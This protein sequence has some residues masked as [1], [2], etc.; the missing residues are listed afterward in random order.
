MP[1]PK[2]QGFNANRQRTLQS[3]RH[4]NDEKHYESRRIVLVQGRLITFN[5]PG[6]T[7]TCDFRIRNPIDDSVNADTA[8]TYDAPP[9]NPRNTPGNSEL[10]SELVRLLDAWPS[11]PA[12]VRSGIMAIVEGVV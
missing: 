5:A 9:Q 11:L 2:S 12:A 1:L 4:N 6:R 8:T 10:D 7:R 3:P